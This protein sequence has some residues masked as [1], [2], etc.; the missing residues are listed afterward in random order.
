MT[1][2]RLP[3]DPLLSGPDDEQRS[4]AD[5]NRRFGASLRK[6]YRETLDEPLSDKIQETLDK[7]K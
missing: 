3:S 2:R 4:V 7:L 6:I 1:D 5:R